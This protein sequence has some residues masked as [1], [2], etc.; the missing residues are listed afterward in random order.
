[1]SSY[2]SSPSAI[3]MQQEPIAKATIAQPGKSI[4]ISYYISIYLSI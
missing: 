4:D 1:M 3:R 2:V